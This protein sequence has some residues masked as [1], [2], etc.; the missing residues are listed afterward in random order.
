MRC[1]LYILFAFLLLAASAVSAQVQYVSDSTLH[2][3]ARMTLGKKDNVLHLSI[4]NVSTDT[5]ICPGTRHHRRAY[6]KSIFRQY[7]MVST[8]GCF[9]LLDT[10]AHP[11][12]FTEWTW[13]AI[14]PCIILPPGQT[15]HIAI[16]LY[17]YQYSRCLYYRH[18]AYAQAHYKS[19]AMIFAPDSPPLSIDLDERS[20]YHHE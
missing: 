4:H 6:G 19:S 20:Y 3:E 15:Y 18:H 12:E 1:C 10:A 11:E 16:T 17:K 5:I 8:N 7:Q 14:R 13:H 9:D 2:I